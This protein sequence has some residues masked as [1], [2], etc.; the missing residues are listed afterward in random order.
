MPIIQMLVSF[1]LLFL[2]TAY[3]NM[4]KLPYP[5]HTRV[6]IHQDKNGGKGL[7]TVKNPGKHAWLF[8]SWIEDELG[9]KHPYVYPDISRIEPFS[10]KRLTISLSENMWKMDR[11]N[12]VWLIVRFIPFMESE[13]NKNHV[14]IPLSFRLKVFIRPQ[15]ISPYLK[16]VLR[17]TQG[18][19]G[20]I[21]IRNDGSHHLS[22]INIT[23]KNKDITIE[24]PGVLPPSGIIESKAAYRTG[25]YNL[26]YIDDDGI[27]KEIKISCF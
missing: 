10:S 5:T 1:F 20:G 4:D 27:K 14:V 25:E 16:P 12:V 8:Q 6:I 3:A 23:N 26:F 21:Q 7:V 2:D 9:Y 13:L 18:N 11:E 17:C 22:I 15:S 24:K 19:K